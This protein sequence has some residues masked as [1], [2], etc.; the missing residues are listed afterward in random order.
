MSGTNIISGF[1][2]T[3]NF[4]ITDDNLVVQTNGSNSNGPSLDITGDLRIGS[5]DSINSNE[6]I[7]SNQNIAG[8][9]LE[10]KTLSSSITK[11]EIKNNQGVLEFDISG[12]DEAVKYLFDISDNFG[13]GFSVSKN[14]DNRVGLVLG[15]TTNDSSVERVELNKY[16]NPNVFYNYDSN[17]NNRYLG[18]AGTNIKFH[19][20]YDINDLSL[21]DIR[22]AMTIDNSGNVGIG[23]NNTPG[24]A[25]N[26]YA[27][28]GIK[29]PS[30]TTAQ[31]PTVT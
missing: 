2:I 5:I 9:K 4:R 16:V 14:I 24:L 10:S 6:L 26:V 22:V 23:T 18:F 8:L 27:N 28:D 3:N 19:T 7:I 15:S 1:E 17:L 21:N 30:G 20:T 25:L 29:L 12:S 13:V 11:T 31:R